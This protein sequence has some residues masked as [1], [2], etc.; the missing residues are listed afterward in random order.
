ME[1]MRRAQ[2]SARAGCINYE[3]PQENFPQGLKPS[4]LLV[5]LGTTERLAEKVEIRSESVQAC[6]AGA[7][8]Q[9]SFCDDYGPAEAVPLLQGLL[10]SIFSASCEVVP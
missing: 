2:K 4:I 10:R 7:E 1:W 9:H 6:V 5:L 8:A 3:H